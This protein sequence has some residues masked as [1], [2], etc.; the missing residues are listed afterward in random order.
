MDESH[1]IGEYV[2]SYGVWNLY[3][4]IARYSNNRIALELE[5]K[6]IEDGLENFEPYAMVTINLPNASIPENSMLDSCGTAEPTG[7]YAFINADLDERFKQFLRDKNV[8][9]YPFR[10]VKYNYGTYELC[11]ILVK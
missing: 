5:H 8:I 11:E 2:D 9:S 7:E 10:T 6:Y 4:Y 1:Y 3:Y